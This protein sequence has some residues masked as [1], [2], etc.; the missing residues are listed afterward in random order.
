M[1]NRILIF[2][3]IFFYITNNLDAQ[4]RGNISDQSNL[5]LPFA[6]IYIE[7]T[8]WG[9]VSNVDGYYELELPKKGLYNIVYYYVGYKPYR[10]TVDYDGGKVVKNVVLK[11]DNH[12]LQELVIY[13]DAEDPAY[14]IIRKAIANRE[15]NK[16]NVKSL[17]A[18]L[19]VKGVVKI[20]DAPKAI[21][22]EDIGDMNGILD[23][24]RQGMVYLSESKSKFYFQL[25]NETKEVMISMIKSGDNSL[26]TA[27][28]FSWASFDLYEEYLKFT[29]SIVSPLADVALN[30]YK[31]K[32]ESTS[33]D[34][35]GFT[36]NKI[37]IIP[38]S[39]NA[40]LLH[41]H[42]FITDDIWNI[43][44]ADLQIYGN[45]LKNTFLDTIEVKQV[46]V[47]TEGRTNWKMFSQVFSFKAGLMGFKMG[48]NF[49]YIFSNYQINKDVSA[50][51]SN[52]ETFKVT[53]NAMQKD[54]SFWAKSRPIPL[55]PEE[56]KDYIKKDSLQAIWNTK[57][58]MDS[59]DRKNNKF[60]FL[61]LLTG[62]SFDNTYEKKSLTFSSPLSTLRFS[63]VEGFKISIDPIW[64]KSDS[65]QRL[66]K[67]QPIIEYGFADKIWKPRINIERTFDNYSLGKLFFSAGRQNQQFDIR[68]P[69][70][71][72]NNS[73][74]TLW[75]KVN[76]IR[77]YQNNLV[78][79]GYSQ[80]IFNGF[81]LYINS[82]Y[83][84]RKP[85]SV[86]TQY[87]FRKKDAP[88]DD[89]IP[90]KDLDADLY[91]ANVYWKNTIRLTIAPGQKYS[92]Y[93]YSKIRDLS[94]WPNITTEY[95][96]G[97]GIST[98]S[99]SFHKL[100][101]RV[102]DYNVNARLI[103]YFQYNVEGG[104]FL[105]NKPSYFA[106]FFHPMGN[107]LLSPIAPDL[108]SF[109]LLP[110]YEFSTG[111][112]YLQFNFRHHF[113]GFVF[114][115]IPLINK[116]PLKL[117]IG[118]SG[119]YTPEKGHY[120]EPFIGIENFR[121]GPISLFDVDYSF[122]FDQSG[123]RDHGVTFRLSQLLNN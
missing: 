15:K 37:K 10:F 32:L 106:D 120:L 72:R 38:K 111:D 42:I 84:D 2:W 85:V 39:Q 55:T 25:P 108:S 44:S 90:R 1:M 43:H 20:T 11:L 7:G 78:S 50:I 80:E 96:T 77:L 103:G 74:T 81:Y 28:Q 123:F 119:L 83:T 105:G 86:S 49:T 58:Y 13:A 51:F 5:S 115:K 57:S 52:K 29:R 36:I 107:E 61:K 54:T 6:T 75:Y 97:L 40:P 30:H 64:T 12:I 70:N 88:Y 17:E 114:D 62:Y 110:Y 104:K 8:S 18:D 100:T 121:I 60:S 73:W 82:Q 65:M 34:N 117:V 23:S 112:Y 113:N 118:S 101:L 69:I 27:N 91:R 76:A 89:N 53:Q 9:T 46:F 71:E 33:V 47:P 116:T 41:G 24:T 63:A 59:L 48:G 92:S 31:F 109:N 67:L 79:L 35:N 26:F 87:S 3:V 122:G 16:T 21:L 56:S 45:A 22:G 95:E 19:Y 93:P 66:W 98:N 14:P 102:R 4:V 99:Q 68:E 94:D